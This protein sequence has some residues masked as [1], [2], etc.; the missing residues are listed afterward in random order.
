MI[1]VQYAI[2]FDAT[3]DY[4]IFLSNFLV[5]IYIL[6]F[7]LFMAS[8]EFLWS[9]HIYDLPFYIHDSFSRDVILP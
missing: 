5:F 7:E 2:I 3:S 9:S 1:I 6:R 8:E 4:N